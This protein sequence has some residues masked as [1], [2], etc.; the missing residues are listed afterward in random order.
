[1]KISKTK[2]LFC[3]FFICFSY[4]WEKWSRLAPI[5]SNVGFLRIFIMKEKKINEF[6]DEA[7]ELL[8]VDLRNALLNG[9]VDSYQVWYRQMEYINEI[10]GRVACAF[11]PYSYNDFCK[12]V[13]Q[14]SDDL[15]ENKIEYDKLFVNQEEYLS[16][17]VKCGCDESKIDD[18][19][20]KIMEE[21]LNLGFSDEI[22]FGVF[23]ELIRRK[24]SKEEFAVAEI[25]IDEGIN[26]YIKTLKRFKFKKDE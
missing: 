21:K 20:G 5:T 4:I 16:I 17:I 14:I 9:F 24:S 6:K 15:L 26:L 23:K 10:I 11:E 8:K 2:E 19:L 22:R 25:V 18:E 12:N 7:I 3:N 13:V 1:M